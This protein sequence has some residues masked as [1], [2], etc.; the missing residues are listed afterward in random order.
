MPLKTNFW[1]EIRLIYN[2]QSS[3][4]ITTRNCY[5]CSRL[6]SLQSL[7]ANIPFYLFGASGIHLEN[8]ET[9]DR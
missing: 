5:T 4:V 2:L 9:A 7:H 8:F 1:L 6:H 3:P